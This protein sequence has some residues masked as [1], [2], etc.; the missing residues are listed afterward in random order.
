MRDR[1]TE[2]A[3]LVLSGQRI[4]G[5]SEV[6]A[7]QRHINDMKDKGTE[8]IFDVKE[9]ERHIDIANTLTIGE[10]E[11]HALHTRGFQN[12]II[13]S[14]FG[15]RKKRSDIRRYREA[16]VQVGRQNGKSFLAGTLA[17]DFA[18]FG[19][20]Q[21]GR[22]FCTATKQD[23]ANIVWDEV[24]KFIQSDKDLAELYKIKTYDRTITSK[25]TG[26]TIK[27]IGR[28]TKSADGFRTILAIVDEYHAHPT[29][30]MYKLMMDGQDMVKNALTIAITTAGFNLKSPCYEQYQFCKKVLEGVV[31]KD[32]LFVYIAELDEEDDIWEK[33]N[34]AKANPLKLFLPDEVTLDDEKL[35]VV[36]NKA[37]DAKEKQGE[38]LVNFETKTLNQWVTYTGGALLDMAA[39]KAGGKLWTLA[40]MKGR[41]GYLGIDLSSGGDLTS[42]SIVFPLQDDNVYIWSHSYM[43]ELRLAEH[44]KSDDAPYGVWKNQGLITLTSGMYGI[45]TDY[46]YIIAD[47]KRMIDEYDIDII[48]CGYDAHNA[49]AFLADLEDVL[50]CDLTEVKQSARSLN[51]TTKDF[52]LSVKAGQVSYDQNNALLSWSATNAIISEP[53]SFGEIKVDKMTQTD[54]IDPIDA[55]IDAWKM[56]F[57]S[58]ENN[59]PDG[60]E[61]LQMW[62]DSM[63]EDEKEGR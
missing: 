2:Y 16:Y 10:G 53:N 32:N 55:I 41:E 5:R 49:A 8:W 43:P 6:L 39:W 52:Q 42:I 15:W 20:Y 22:I 57:L 48:G 3:K 21:Y 27:A 40:D 60:E 19:G 4:C 30:Q 7:A 46:K 47:L 59:V 1:T 14:L 26:T 24:A 9:A 50:P 56:W 62:L 28:D 63:G 38:E 45:K 37:I 23:Q 36:A 51:D 31:Q 13:G 25:V 61:A 33:E 12:F 11:A 54:R 29:N 35:A 44:I 18:T 58:K 17:N 34:W